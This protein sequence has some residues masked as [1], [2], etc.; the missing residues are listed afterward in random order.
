[1]KPHLMFARRS[2]LA[3]ALFLAAIFSIAAQEKTRCNVKI[4]LLQVNDVYQFAPVDQGTRGGLARLLTL[5]KSIQQENPNTLFLMAG[6]TIS[7]SVES[8]TYKGAQ[9]IDAWNA[10][11]LDYATFGNHEFDFGPDVLKQRMQESKFAWTAANVIDTTTNQ[12]FNDAKRYVVREFGGVK[13]GIFGLVLPETKITSRPGPNV[14][15]RSPCDT[16]K[17]VVSELHSQGVK[18]VVALTHLSMREDKEVARC[19]GVNLIIGGHEHTLL[20]SQAGNAPIFKMT[21]DGRELGRFDLNI[22]PATGELESIDWQVIP[23]DSTTPEAPEFAAV[24]QKYAG[25]L[26]ELAKPVGSTSVTLDA[27]SL[28]S[29]TRETNVGDFVADAFRKATTADIGFMNGGSIRADNVFGPGKL[30]MRDVLSI[31]P[32]KNKLVKIEVTGAMLRAALEHGVSRS[33]EDSQPGGFPQVSGIVFS[34]DASRPPGARLVDVKVNGVALDDAKKYTLTT[35]TF[36][37]LDGGDGYTMFKGAPVVTPPERA[38]IDVDA[39]IK[40]IG[41]QPIAPKVEGRIKR[42]D[43]V[44]KSG[45]NCN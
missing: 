35:T 38:P 3:L 39:V 20:Q 45:P 41:S 27:R 22:S 40:A 6:D 24:Y 25:L 23:V 44:Q 17:E 30:T 13:I 42:L 15:F 16:A 36:I 29:R 10:I 19:A 12:T 21:S 26:T 14:E 33:A 4:T 2:A 28:E 11:G 34:F 31:L 7:P 9:M 37:A 5:H 43:T 8:I 18:V 1:M 32:F